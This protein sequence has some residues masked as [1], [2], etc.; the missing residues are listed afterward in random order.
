[1]Y[2]MA[3]GRVPGFALA[4]I[5]AFH[6]GLGIATSSVWNEGELCEV[7]DHDSSVVFPV[8]SAS[9]SSSEDDKAV[10]ISSF[11]LQVSQHL[12]ST[13]GQRQSHHS[14]MFRFWI[15]EVALIKQK[16]TGV[17]LMVCGI[18]LLSAVCW[19]FAAPVKTP[20]ASS[21]A[22]QVHS[23]PHAGIPA[24]GRASLDASL[25]GVVA[26]AGKKVK[27]V[28][29]LD[30]LRVIFISTVIVNHFFPYYYMLPGTLD[31]VWFQHEPMKFFGTL[32]GFIRMITNKAPESYGLAASLNYCARV[33]ARFAPAYWLA[34]VWVGFLKHWSA[35]FIA[36]PAQAVFSQGWF[37]ANS[38]YCMEQD[39][40]LCANFVGWFTS[41]IVV[42]SSMFPLL[43]NACR[44]AGTDRKPGL[45]FATVMVLLGLRAV[46]R[47]Y[48]FH[49][50]IVGAKAYGILIDFTIGLLCAQL[51]HEFPEWLVHW[52][53]WGYIFDA[54][55]VGYYLGIL[56]VKEHLTLCCVLGTFI[57]PLLIISGWA[58]AQDP[59][60][61]GSP[62]SGLVGRC[63]SM[64]PITMLAEFSFGA[65]I[66]QAPIAYAID[67]VAE[68]WGLQ[69]WRWCHFFLTWTVAVVSEH[70]ME[71]R[72]RNI[73][74]VRI[75]GITTNVKTHA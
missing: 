2:S 56:F 22:H 37:R 54:T 61:D 16:K 3:S 65:Y 50:A 8:F 19:V 27:V 29:A 42:V 72:I 63:V 74:E 15:E 48:D 23:V 69:R 39:F 59:D 46:V 71:R 66:F 51:C 24:A 12:S 14:S 25:G 70:L 34:L 9:T 52:S 1:M 31:H 73:I 26:R 67:L 49:P 55:L 62:S 17:A 21:P 7:K 18:L 20:L 35:P 28:K 53:G 57:W 6:V 32:S 75:K 60:S 30:G 45:A 36:W 11:L 5:F 10:D 38:V 41:G 58:S 33:I 68:T 40:M 47:A 44:W 13:A 43:W 4:T 64:K